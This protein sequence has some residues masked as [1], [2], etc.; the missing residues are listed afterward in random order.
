VDRFR[1]ELKNEANSLSNNPLTATEDIIKGGAA[2]LAAMITVA[3][4]SQSIWLHEHANAVIIAIF[5]LGYIGIIF[6]EVFEFNKAGVAL[7]MSTGLWISDADYFD[8]AGTASNTVEV[9]DS[10]Q[11]FRVVTN[12]ITTTSQ[13]EL[14]WTIGFLTFFLF[15]ILNN[16]TVTIVIRNVW[17][18]EDIDK[19]KEPNE[20]DWRCEWWLQALC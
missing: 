6:E 7:L 1:E 18:L 13:K 8:S 9:V 14:F 15:S 16:L 19:N 3:F 2:H 10:H 11:G 5:V 12:Q 20:K 4:V 17:S